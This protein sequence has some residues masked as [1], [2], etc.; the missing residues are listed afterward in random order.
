M[1]DPTVVPAGALSGMRVAL[2]ASESADLPRLGLSEF[3]CRLAIAEIGRALMIA[4]A[5]VV[6][7]GNLEHT[8]YT[9]VLINEAQRFGGRY[10]VLELVLPESEYGPRTNTQLLE[11]RSRLGEIGKVVLVKSDG[12]IQNLHEHRPIA[13][14]DMD[15]AR[16]L[17]A[18]R[19]FV[20]RN[21]D[22]RVLVGGRLEGYQGAEPG[23]IEEAR[24]SAEAGGTLLVA[25][26]FGGAAAAVARALGAF[27]EGDWSG[28]DFP[29]GKESK[30]VEFALGQLIESA[31]SFE[32]ATSEQAEL[33]RTLSVSHRPADIA[34]S[35]VQLLSTK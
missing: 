10:G 1:T 29:I 15:V 34:A 18:M 14:E 35:V 23:V 6:Y 11:T 25:G 13:R 31:P 2:S 24:L 21:T 16:A 32:C 9:D 3:H 33:Q 22:A 27:R 5:T 4:G 28:S 7:G 30:E 19:S 26:G 8:S 12:A 20:A 17:T